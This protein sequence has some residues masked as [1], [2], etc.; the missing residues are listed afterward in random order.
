MIKNSFFCGVIVAGVVSVLIAGCANTGKSS[1]GV[2]DAAVNDTAVRAALVGSFRETA[3]A[4]LDRLNQTELQVACTDAS[5]TGKPLDDKVRDALQGKA[6]AA[7]KYPADGTYLG[8]WKRGEAIAQS[9]RGL[10][11]SDAAGTAAGGNCYACHQIDKK[12]IAHGNIG[13]TLAGYG[14]LRG[15]SEPILKY[16]WA[17]IWNSHAFNACANM[18]RFGDAGILTE[19]QI[20]DVMALLLDPQSPVNQ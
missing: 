19:A 8:D 9:G 2:D 13:P 12:E 16:T 4:K 18:P 17:R 15:N 6:L 11:F 20:K 3:S 5:R 1:A 10:Q 14:K 7:V